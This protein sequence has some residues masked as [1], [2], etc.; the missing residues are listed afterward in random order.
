LLYAVLVFQ[1]VMNINYTVIS[2]KYSWSSLGFI[3]YNRSYYKL[4]SNILKIIVTLW[5]FFY[6]WF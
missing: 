4:S 1:H 5:H 3:Y 6:R 2:I